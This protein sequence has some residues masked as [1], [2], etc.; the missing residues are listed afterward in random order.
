MKGKIFVL[1][2]LILLLLGG[3]VWLVVLHLEESQKESI[4]APFLDTVSIK[5]TL[6]RP[7]IVGIKKEEEPPK[8]GESSFQEIREKRSQE[9]SFKEKISQR[10]KILLPERNPFLTRA[11]EIFFSQKPKMEVI[12]YLNI[13]AIFYSPPR[14]YAIIDGRIVREHDFVD[15]KRVE[16]I[17]E[18]AIILSDEHREYIIYL[19]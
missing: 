6:S 10:V 7:G 13:S 16:R 8:M 5:K 2:F 17:E 14:S 11:E 4:E 18:E 9:G 15:G 12:D 3:V 19:K 1:I